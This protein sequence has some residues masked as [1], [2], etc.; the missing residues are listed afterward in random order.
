MNLEADP[1]GNEIG[2]FDFERSRVHVIRRALRP[3]N[4][5]PTFSITSHEYIGFVRRYMYLLSIIQKA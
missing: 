4:G 5:C 1:K 2:G 3:N